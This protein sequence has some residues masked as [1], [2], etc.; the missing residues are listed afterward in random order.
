MCYLQV[1]TNS[2]YME[3]HLAV[4]DEDIAAGAVPLP[5]LPRHKQVRC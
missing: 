1:L 3:D 2:V 4:L 5:L